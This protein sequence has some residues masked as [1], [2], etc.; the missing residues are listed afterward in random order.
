MHHKLPNTETY[1]FAELKN[2][3]EKAFDYLYQNYSAALY[4]VLFQV[5]HL[6]ED[7]NDALQEVFVKIWKNIDQY[8]QTRSSF[9]TWM[10]NIARNH[11]IDKLRSKRSK[12]GKILASDRNYLDARPQ[13][14]TTL[15]D[16][17][18]LEKMTATLE[19]EQQKI[20]QLIYFKGYTQTETAEELN[21]PLGT[22]KSRTRL[23]IQ[24]L[25]IFFN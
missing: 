7:A 1:L 2:R 24:K 10:L 8:D 25:R 20:I 6:E 18:G 23:A 5:L 15:I 3:N 21:I 11:A 17:I 12:A 9:F 4:G 19:I 22:V 13:K 14:V 16:A